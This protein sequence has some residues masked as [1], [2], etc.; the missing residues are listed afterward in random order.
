[1]KQLLGGVLKISKVRLP[2]EWWSLGKSMETQNVR[3]SFLVQFSLR[4]AHAEGLTESENTLWK[5]FCKVEPQSDDLHASIERRAACLRLT[6]HYM[7]TVLPCPALCI[8]DQQQGWVECF[9]VRKIYFP[10]RAYLAQSHL[11]N[12]NISRL[13]L[14]SLIMQYCSD[15]IEVEVRY[16]KLINFLFENGIYT[17]NISGNPHVVECEH[18]IIDPPVH[19]AC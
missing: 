17:C 19:S 2:Q 8:Y 13:S 9:W 4:N 12:R 15:C 14:T 5:S 16:S 3:L 1:M 10:A 11:M 6:M 18:A 7:A